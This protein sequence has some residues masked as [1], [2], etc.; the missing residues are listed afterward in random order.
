MA[1]SAALLVTLF[2]EVIGGPLAAIC[3]LGFLLLPKMMLE[4]FV[5]P[6]TSTFATLLV[7]LGLWRLARI[8]MAPRVSLMDSGTF[9]LIVGLMVPTRPLDAIAAASL[10]P[11]WLGGIWRSGNSA[12]SIAM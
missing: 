1:A 5:T 8:E 2:R 4:T 10:Y 3:A 12:R 7:F 9:S 11:F 6:W